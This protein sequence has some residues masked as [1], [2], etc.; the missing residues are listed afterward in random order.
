MAAPGQSWPAQL[1]GR[2]R[3]YGGR[4]GPRPSRSSLA[5]RRPLAAAG[6]GAAA[7]LRPGRAGQLVHVGIGCTNDV[8]Q[9]GAQI[10]EGASWGRSYF[11]LA[12]LVLQLP[13]LPRAGP[14]RA[15]AAGQSRPA[16]PARGGTPGA[17]AKPPR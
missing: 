5:R 17:A 11:V 9:T 16:A 10:A 3:R 6:R 13:G 15:V 14:G 7:R 8:Q 2:R 1:P 12:S 4:D